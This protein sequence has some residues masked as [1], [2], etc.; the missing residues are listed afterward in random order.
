MAVLVT[1]EEAEFTFLKEKVNATD[2]NLSVHLT[3]AGRGGIY[4]CKEELCRK[5]TCFEI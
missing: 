2:G 3:Q 4:F 5:K 1:V